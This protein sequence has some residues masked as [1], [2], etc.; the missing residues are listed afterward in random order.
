M[1]NAPQKRQQFAKPK[2]ESG[3]PLPARTRQLYPWTEMKVGD[4][5][6]FPKRR[7]EDVNVTRW[8]AQKRTGFKFS[9]HKV[10]GGVRVWRVE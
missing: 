4:S 6:W 3:V 2:I 8:K 5:L 1:M 7:P 9:Q 10:K